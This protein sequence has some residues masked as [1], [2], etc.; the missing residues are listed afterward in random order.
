MSTTQQPVWN[1]SQSGLRVMIGEVLSWNPDLPPWMAMQ[2]LNNRL[3]MVIDRRMWS[4]LLVKSQV[5]VPDSYT[6]GTVTC[7][8]SSATVAGVATA[9]PINDSVNT[10]IPLAITDTG[11]PIDVTPASMT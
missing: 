6:T 11:V 7:T 1:K 9:W 5:I 8:R 3:R 4:G 2:S 10:T